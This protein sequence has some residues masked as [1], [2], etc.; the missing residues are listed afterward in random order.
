MKNKSGA[1]AA[2]DS[3]ELIKKG[4]ITVFIVCGIT[5][6]FAV[7][8]V[9][10][11][12]KSFASSEAY[13]GIFDIVCAGV[14]AVSSYMFVKGRSIGR[15]II[16]VFYCLYMGYVMLM[17]IFA[18]L[19]CSFIVA[20]LNA[21]FSDD[22]SGMEL[23]MLPVVPIVLLLALGGFAIRAAFISKSVKAYCASKG[24]NGG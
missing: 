12:I 1:A 16:G 13:T 5:A 19:L 24:Q 17:Y 6:A 4:K 2:S 7:C 18:S 15:I 20:L 14:L 9:I 21:L 8:A 10:G 22:P 3:S 23:E 11:G